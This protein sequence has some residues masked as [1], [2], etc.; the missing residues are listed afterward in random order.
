MTLN[1][2]R[3]FGLGMLVMACALIGLLNHVWTTHLRRAEIGSGILLFAVVLL[4]TLFNARK[5]LPFLPLLPASSWMRVHIYIGFF[6]VWLF[7]LHIGGRVPNGGLEVTLTIL[8]LAVAASGIVGLA[9]TRWVPS[10]LTIH[11]ENLIFERIPALRAAVRIE[12]E[13]LVAGSITVTN[14]STIADFYKARLQAYFAR[15]RFLLS[16]LIGH[17]KPIFNLLA[18]VEALDRYLNTREREF[19]VQI[20][21]LIR[22]KDN[23]DFQFA[24]Q[25]L[26]KGWLFVHIPLTYS[27]IVFAVVHGVLAWSF[28]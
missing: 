11:G 20:T 24:G 25:L 14:S 9:I 3:Y 2:R 5:K 16:H 27:L 4:L 18:E 8:F 15:S 10:R 1:N 12:V 17:R 26:L 28:S 7:W 22:A 13:N 19:I 6:S 21:E 23:L